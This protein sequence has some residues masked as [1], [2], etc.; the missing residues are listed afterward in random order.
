M[1]RAKLFSGGSRTCRIPAGAGFR[2]GAM[3]D[4]QVFIIICSVAIGIAIIAMGWYLFGGRGRSRGDTMTF[5]CLSC[6]AAVTAEN[7]AEPFA[8][9]PECGK[10]AARVSRAKCPAC[11][12]ISLYSRT[13][14]TKEGAAG[15]EAMKAQGGGNVPPM[16]MMGGAGF[17]QDVQYWLKQSDGSYAWSEWVPLGSQKALALQNQYVCPKCGKTRQE[18]REEIKNR[19]K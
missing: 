13:Q 17:P 16:M 18:A 9:C 14:L 7:T 2:A 5:E 6:N 1:K 12:E 19:R 10:Y 11:E 4:K 15:Y 3:E 8:K